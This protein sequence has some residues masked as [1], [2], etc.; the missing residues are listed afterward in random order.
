MRNIEAEKKILQR[1]YMLAG[2]VFLLGIGALSIGTEMMVLEYWEKD[3]TM[4]WIWQG[5][6]AVVH[7]VVISSIATTV[8]KQQE[9]E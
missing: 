6:W 1:I 4:F 2:L 8:K 5:V 9:K 7:G 3:P